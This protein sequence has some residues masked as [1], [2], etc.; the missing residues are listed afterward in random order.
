MCVREI[1]LA[2][3]I[4]MLGLNFRS[5]LP[6]CD[7]IFV[8]L[9]FFPH[10]NIYINTDRS[11][12]S[13][14]SWSWSYGNWINNFL[15]N[16]CLSPLTLWVRIPLMVRCTRYNIMRYNLSVNYGWSMVFSG[17]YGFIHQ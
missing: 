5:V 7:V 3:E 16:Q 9:S 14:P 8:F 2:S 12:Q 10:L 15:C 1:G 6:R 4:M 17:Y 13:L 11:P